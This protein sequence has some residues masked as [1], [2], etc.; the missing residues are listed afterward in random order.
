MSRVGWKILI[1]HLTGE[2]SES[3]AFIPELEDSFW[4]RIR[5]TVG[6]LIFDTV[7]SQLP[8]PVTSVE[9]KQMLP[10]AILWLD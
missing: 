4:K 5:N 1:F 6:F 7:E 10:I 8:F 9:G 3:E 2:Q